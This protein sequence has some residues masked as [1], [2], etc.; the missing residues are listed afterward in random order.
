MQKWFKSTTVFRG[1]ENGEIF[2]F[3]KF[4]ICEHGKITQRFRAQN[5]NEIRNKTAV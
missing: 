4:E 2:C 3:T 1:I 5:L